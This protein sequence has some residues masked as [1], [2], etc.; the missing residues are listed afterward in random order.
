MNRLMSFC[1]IALMCTALFVAESFANL[2]GVFDVDQNFYWGYKRGEG[3]HKNG[4][5]TVGSFRLQRVW[6]F[7]SFRFR[8]GAEYAGVTGA[9]FVS[10]E[11]AYPV[12]SRDQV[13]VQ[14]GAAFYFSYVVFENYIGFLYMRDAQQDAWNVDLSTFVRYEV[15]NTVTLE[16]MNDLIFFEKSV[17]NEAWLQTVMRRTYDARFGLSFAVSNFYRTGF[18][19]ERNGLRNHLWFGPD[20]YFGNDHSPGF[21][22][23]VLVGT[24]LAQIEPNEKHDLL[25]LRLAIKYDF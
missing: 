19:Q 20:A 15:S 3:L 17:N 21:R 7:V 24:G 2:D 23:S 16:L 1:G 5:R 11:F 22:V 9:D 18:P 6:E 4:I 13:G 8:G 10:D 14:I 12:Y 25:T